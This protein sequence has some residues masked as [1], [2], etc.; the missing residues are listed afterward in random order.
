RAG[1]SPRLGPDRGASGEGSGRRIT[2]GGLRWWTPATT[3]I[4]ATGVLVTAAIAL[5]SSLPTHPAEPPSNARFT[6]VRVMPGIPLSDYRQR[7]TALVPVERDGEG[8]APPAVPPSPPAGALG[9]APG[10]RTVP[11][12]AAPGDPTSAVGPVRAPLGP[13]S[14]SAATPTTPF[15]PGTT[16]GPASTHDVDIAD[17]FTVPAGFEIDPVLLSDYTHQARG[18]AFAALGCRADPGR[19]ADR[20]T[21]D[22]LVTANALAPDGRVVPPEV[23]AQR[24]VTLLDTTRAGP[25]GAEPLGVVVATDVELTGL[26]GEP[27]LLTWTMWRS[28]E[29]ARVHGDWLDDDLA[30]RLRAT[31]DLDTVTL[32]LWIPLPRRPGAYVVRVALARD[33]AALATAASAPFD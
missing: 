7:S 22:Y 3:A 30:Y 16:T 10:G 14:A 29:Q 17:G 27:V 28:G 18:A 33:G 19:C 11:A 9:V 24:V 1:R 21:M 26:R 4:L 25:T 20:V 2:T 6:A 13:R 5:V 23:A 8:G 31:S 15:G 12:G 32:D